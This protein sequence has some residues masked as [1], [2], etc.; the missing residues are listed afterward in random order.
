MSSPLCF[1]FYQQLLLPAKLSVTPQLS[2]NKSSDLLPA[3]SHPLS[4]PG[5]HCWLRLS[6]PASIYLHVIFLHTPLPPCPSF[7]L[8]FH[9]ITNT[10][11]TSLSLSPSPRRGYPVRSAAH[12]ATAALMTR[13]RRRRTRNSRQ[14]TAA[15]H[16]TP[17]H[18]SGAHMCMM[19]VCVFMRSCVT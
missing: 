11:Q 12:A 17:I 9:N 6:F 13:R 2:A 5:S 18:L 3:F 15:P 1:S 7:Q 8:L 10:L 19:C 4:R 14:S 16:W